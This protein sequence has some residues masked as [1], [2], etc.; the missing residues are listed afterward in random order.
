MKLY[1]YKKIC[2]ICNSFLSKKNYLIYFNSISHFNIIREHQSYYNKYKDIKKNNILFIFIKNLCFFIFQNLKN[3]F[4]YLFFLNSSKIIKNFNKKKLEYLFISHKINSKMKN[5]YEDSY[6][7]DF[8]LEL[9]K[10]NVNYQVCYI[11]NFKNNTNKKL[12]ILNGNLLTFKDQI[13]IL[14]KMLNIAF[15]I[16]IKYLKCSNKN[17]KKILLI[18][19]LNSL[20]RDTYIN[21]R[22]YL[23]ILKILKVVEVKS[24]LITFEGYSWEKLI[25]YNVKKYSKTKIIGY[26]HTGLSKY[27][28]SILNTSSSLLPNKVFTVNSYD[29]TL[30]KKNKNFRNVI[31]KNIGKSS[32]VQKEKN[33]WKIKRTKEKDKIKVLIANDGDLNEFYDI[34]NLMFSLNN[35]QNISFIVRVHPVIQLQAKK[36]FNK[37][38]NQQHKNFFTFSENKNFDVDLKKSHIIIYRGSS[39][40][41]NA[42][43][44][45]LLPIFFENQNMI[46]NDALYRLRT[47]RAK[48][49][50]ARQLE[51]FLN[52]IKIKINF[53]NFNNYKKY[54]LQYFDKFNSTK[55]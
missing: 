52:N 33:E 20:S 14:N 21:H 44:N 41:I 10:R 40:V 45:G 31:I 15:F 27:Q 26:Q 49:Q 25:S 18:S 37:Y 12:N 34:L 24:L 23:E 3:I 22:I 46:V 1:N 11:N 48:V 8:I 13:K 32:F 54:T 36:I 5:I 55:L 6:I 29:K 30:L 2:K 19:S 51:K 47:K 35:L 39:L 38:N 53:F 4:I 7:K 16:F 42:I 17:E 28:N 9:D 43:R 50:N